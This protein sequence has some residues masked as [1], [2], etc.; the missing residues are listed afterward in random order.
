M[1]YD[2]EVPQRDL[3]ALAKHIEDHGIDAFGDRLS[4]N[5]AT[6]SFHLHPGRDPLTEE[7]AEALEEAVRS[8][9]YVEPYDYDQLRSTEY[10]K[11]IPIVSQVEAIRKMAKLLLD[12]GVDIGPDMEGILAE[13]DAIKTEIPKERESVSPG[14]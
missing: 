11:R 8:Y 6:V 14:G 1:R 13:A 7:Q 4:T 10:N 3:H 2:F 12:S 5:G 9:V